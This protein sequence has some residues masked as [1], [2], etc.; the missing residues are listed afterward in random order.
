MKV[1]DLDQKEIDIID[2]TVEV[3]RLAG[4]IIYYVYGV[5][6]KGFFEKSA[7]LKVTLDQNEA[8]DYAEDLK[9]QLAAEA[10]Q[11]SSMTCG[12]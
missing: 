7:I 11:D 8:L 4:N 9:V 5:Y 10:F 3:R 6:V 12:V 1:K 2:C